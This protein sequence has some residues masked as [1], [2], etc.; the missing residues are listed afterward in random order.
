MSRLQAEKQV[1]ENVQRDEHEVQRQDRQHDGVIP[2]ALTD[3]LDS[4][5]HTH[6]DPAAAAT[7]AGRTRVRSGQVR[8]RQGL[9]LKESPIAL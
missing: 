7:A 2:P 4:V 1:R 3:Q 8:S 5:L 9:S 6:L